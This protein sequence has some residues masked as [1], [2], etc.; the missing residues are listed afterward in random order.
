MP[1]TKQVTAI[2]CVNCGYWNIPKIDKDGNI[3]Q[4]KICKNRNCRTLT[5]DGRSDIRKSE[6]FKIHAKTLYERTKDKRNKNHHSRQPKVVIAQVYNHTDL[7]N[8]FKS[9]K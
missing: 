8:K 4:I 7:S 3:I 1:E 5:F 9:Q 2:K 6:K